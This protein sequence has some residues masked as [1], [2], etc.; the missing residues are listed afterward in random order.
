MGHKVTWTESAVIDAEAIAEYIA[1]D[2]PA[3]AANFTLKM[4]VLA[5]SLSRLPNRGRILPEFPCEDLR[6][7]IRGNFRLIFQVKD[8]NVYII[9]IFHGA[10]IINVSDLNG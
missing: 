5:E 1:R 8:K 7:I 6:E 4:R 10:R 2:S 9:R 3:Y